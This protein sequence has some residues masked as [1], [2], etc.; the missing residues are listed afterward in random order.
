[1]FLDMF[2]DP[3]TNPKGWPR[4]RVGGAADVQGGLQV[5]AARATLPLERPYLRVAN[6]YRSYLDLQEVKK[7]R[8]T[9]SELARTRLQSGDL[10]IVEG[11]GNPFE[12]GRVAMW[13]DEIADCVHQNHLIRARPHR[14]VILPR[15]ACAFLNSE[16]GRAALLRSGKTTSGLSTI[17]TSNV[18][19]AP[20]LVPPLE[21]QAHF[22]S[23]CCSF[24]RLE[25]QQS[26]ALSKAEATFAALLAEVFSEET[27]IKQGSSGAAEILVPLS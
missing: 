3:A 17:S 15:Y 11:H 10:L 6:V 27:V 7:I 20:I 25:K 13:F 8:L 4:Q 14:D 12:V 1:L 23:L 16:A 21:R 18:K 5:T 22:E 2:G 24:L 19:D 9:E 26:D